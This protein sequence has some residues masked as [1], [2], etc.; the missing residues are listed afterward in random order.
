VAFLDALGMQGRVVGALLLR[1]LQA[2]YGRNNFGFL[3][4]IME[5]LM[6]A[7]GVLTLWRL[8]RGP[9]DRGVS[10]IAVTLTGY[11]PLLLFRHAISRSF[12]CIR[13]N[14]ALLYHRRVT[15]LDLLWSSFLSEL[16]GNILAFA[17]AF[18]V[19]YACDLIDWP[20]NPPLVFLGYFYMVWF[21]LSVALVVSALAEFSDLVE[22]I[23]TPISYLMVPLSGAYFLAGWLPER[24]REYY[25]M[26]PSV[27]AFEMIRSGFFG[28]SVPGYWSQPY[29]AAVAALCTLY[30]LMLFRR[31]RHHIK[32]E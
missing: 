11:L 30:G 13:N 9:Y 1:E 24:Y 20:A 23:W 10:V 3:W 21:T 15:I 2:R 8:A 7:A 29:I 31:V 14:V 22:K 27:S 6:F 32:L 18:T 25:L 5:P 28:E 26:F 17:F 4:L 16:A 12:G 19:L